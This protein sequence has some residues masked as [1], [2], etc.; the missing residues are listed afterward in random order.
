[1]G[2]SS[3]DVSAR[4]KKTTKFFKDMQKQQL[5]RIKER[6]GIVFIAEFVPSA[7]PGGEQVPPPPC[8]LRQ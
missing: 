8:F 7:S 5:I 6:K 1:L 2:Y 4:F 3:K